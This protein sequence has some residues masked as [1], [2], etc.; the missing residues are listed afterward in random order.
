V[1]IEQRP[2]GRW[3]NQGQEMVVF[4]FY[5]F[6]VPSPFFFV[7]FDADILVRVCFVAA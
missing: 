3:E 7:L 2:G 4:I 5:F 1:Q 6:I